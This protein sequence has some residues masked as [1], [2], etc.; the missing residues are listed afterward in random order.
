MRLGDLVKTEFLAIIKEPPRVM[1]PFIWPG[2]KGNLVK[3]IV[4]YIPYGRIYVEPFAGAASVFWH[5]PKP[6][7]VEV[8]NDLD[9]DVIN[10]YR[11][12]KDSYKFE[13]LFHKIVSTPYARIEFGRAIQ[14]LKAPDVNDIDKAWAFF[15]RQNQ[16]IN[17]IGL[18]ESNWSRALYATN[19]DIAQNVSRWRSRLKM[20][21]FWHERLREVHIYNMDA[22]QCIKQW[23]N[24]DTVFYLDPPY[25]L[26]TRKARSIYKKEID[27]SYHEKLVDILLSVK[28]KVILSCYDHQ[29][30]HP[31]T[32]SGWQKVTIDTVCYMAGKHRG[33]KTR[34]VGNLRLHASRRETIYINFSLTDGETRDLI[35]VD[36]TEE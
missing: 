13:I 2:G 28:G 19:R 25:I 15:V 33:S 6:F 3:W 10:F 35:N 31:L 12:L 16:G 14:M 32:K 9:R 23:D 7:A 22:I 30:Y 34:G 36:L 18:S 17:G 4:Q 21:S 29:T 26:D 1:A 8:L 20:L 27:L 5:L 11:T 24:P